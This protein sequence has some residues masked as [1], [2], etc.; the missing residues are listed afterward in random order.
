MKL[1]VKCSAWF[2][3]A[4]PGGVIGA[5]DI[6]WRHWELAAFEAAKAQ[7]K[8]ILLS[9]GM[10]GCAACARMESIT[11]TDPGVI[12]LITEH[13]IAIE[14]DAGS[15]PRHWRALFRLG[16]AGD[17]FHGAGRDPGARHP[18]Q[19]VTKKLQTNPRGHGR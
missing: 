4:L 18:R 10:E 1:L 3:L 15:T 19:P 9:V 16:V 5:A 6:D 14:V 7:D 13:F 12:D 8:V 17:D 11:Y 2:I